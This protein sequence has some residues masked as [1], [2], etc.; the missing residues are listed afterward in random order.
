MEFYIP[1]LPSNHLPRR[2]YHH[3][4]H[5]LAPTPVAP[6]RAAQHTLLARARLPQVMAVRGSAGHGSGVR[7]RIQLLAAV[8]ARQTPINHYQKLLLKA[9]PCQQPTIKATVLTHDLEF[10]FKS[11][12]M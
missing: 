9:A 2:P 6:T 8:R 7:W 10:K 12:H 1:L 11:N 3:H 4:H 5:P